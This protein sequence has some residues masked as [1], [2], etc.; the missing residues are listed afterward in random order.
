MQR[1]QAFIGMNMIP[2]TKCS[3]FKYPVIIINPC[4]TCFEI[5]GSAGD[6]AGTNGLCTLSIEK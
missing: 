1:E 5:Y 4:T 3:I 6:Y 2:K